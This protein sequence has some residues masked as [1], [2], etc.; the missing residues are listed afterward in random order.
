ML[1]TTFAAAAAAALFAF[2]APA[3]AQAYMANPGLSTELPSN[4]EPV[5]Y[6]HHRRHYRHRHYNR[7]R[8]YRRYSHRRCWNERIRV[9]VGPGY[10]VW[11]TH[12]RCGWR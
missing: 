3:P 4:V 10:Y 11:R 6:R 12:R 1:R 9:R 7:H 2:A 8:H 5:Q